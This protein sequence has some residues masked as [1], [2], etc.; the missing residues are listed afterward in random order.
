MATPLSEDDVRTFFAANNLPVKAG[1]ANNHVGPYDKWGIAID[2]SVTP[3]NQRHS[4]FELISPVMPL[5]RSLEVMK[6]VFDWMNATGGYT[7]DSCG[8]HVGVSLSKQSEMNK[9]N[10][11]KLAL[12]IKEDEILR[13]FKRSQSPWV[14]PIRQDMIHQAEYRVK[15]ERLTSNTIEQFLISVVPLSKAYSANMGRLPN[16]VEFRCMGDN[17][18]TRYEDCKA[19]ILHYAEIMRAACNPELL[20]TEYE[21][22]LQQYIHELCTYSPGLRKILDD[23][24]AYVKTIISRDMGRN[25]E[26]V[27]AARST[28]QVV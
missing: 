27:K 9:I 17:Y 21:A 1:R 5:D 14:K 13:S 15:S 3:A 2:G 7:N 26:R 10:K 16:Y 12:L 22:K 4:K 28:I 8:F 24:G 18:S 19:T 11:L 25:V 23:N 20:K 6:L